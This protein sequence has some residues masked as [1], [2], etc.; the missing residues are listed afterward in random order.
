[1]IK[2][3]VKNDTKIEENV[4]LISFLEKILRNYFG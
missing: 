2:R 4:F 3:E 1:M